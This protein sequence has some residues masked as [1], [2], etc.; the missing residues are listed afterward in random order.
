MQGYYNLLEALGDPKHPEH[1][2]LTDWI[3][4]P[5]DAGEFDLAGANGRLKSLKA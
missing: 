5:F 4:G 1:E 3:G 2:E